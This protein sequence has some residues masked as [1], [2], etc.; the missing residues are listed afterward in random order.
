MVLLAG[1]LLSAVKCQKCSSVHQRITTW[2]Q[3][4]HQHH[5]WAGVISK[6]IPYLQIAQKNIYICIGRIQG[7]IQA[8]FQLRSLT[9]SQ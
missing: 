3:R 7:S 5:L 2:H 9:D 4:H 8:D 6:V 1:F